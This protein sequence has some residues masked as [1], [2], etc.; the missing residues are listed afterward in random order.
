MEAIPVAVNDGVSLV[1]GVETE[2]NRVVGFSYNSFTVVED[3]DLVEKQWI[4]YR[5][6]IILIN[7]RT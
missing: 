5:G 2:E 6:T 7:S 4:E 1:S 3:N